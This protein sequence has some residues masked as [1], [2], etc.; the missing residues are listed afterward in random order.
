MKRLFDLILSAVLLVLLGPIMVVVA[1]L[2]RLDSKGPA[3]FI[4]TRLGLNK[5][6][7][8]MYKFRTM[9][10]DTPDVA[11]HEA[12]RNAITKVGGILRKTKLD[13]L[14]Q[15][16]NVI[17]GE[18]S[19][20][21]PRPCLPNQ[22]RLVE[23]REAEGVFEIKPGITGIAQVQGVAMDEPERLA[24]LDGAYKQNQNF[25]GDLRLMVQTVLG[26]GQGDQVR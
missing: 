17:K 21:G 15:L 6:P 16:I 25:L 10:S 24:Q 7:Y 19:F 8:R 26:A 3:L 22:E 13:E 11:T 20:V 23:L 9:A 2:V 18:M 1:V 14:P 5:R 4:Q 12:P